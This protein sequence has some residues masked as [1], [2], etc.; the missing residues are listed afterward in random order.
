MAP[1]P[2][3]PRALH[4]TL[5]TSRW[6]C[7]PSVYVW[8]MLYVQ[9]HCIIPYSGETQLCLSLF[10]GSLHLYLFLRSF[11]LSSI[12]STFLK[13]LMVVMTIPVV[14]FSREGYKIR[15]VFDLKSNVVK[16]NYQICQN[17]TFKVN[18]LMSK[19][20]E[21]FLIVFIEKY[22]L[23]TTFLDNIIF[24]ITLFSKMMPN[25]W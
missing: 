24:W 23:R 4:C 8:C 7:C 18:F 17:L 21:I 14:E 16:W 15:K 11:P 25:F 12:V 13:F 2:P 3:P 20:I 6:R 19:I 5:L 22:K 1:C 9:Y 10:I